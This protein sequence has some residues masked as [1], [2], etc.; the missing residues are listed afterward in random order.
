VVL[1]LVIAPLF[2]TLVE[3]RAH[4]L[5]KRVGDLVSRAFAAR[6]GVEAPADDASLSDRR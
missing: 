2:Y 6:G 5:S 3:K 4:S 1:S